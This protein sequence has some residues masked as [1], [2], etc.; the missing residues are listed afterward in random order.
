MLKKQDSNINFFDSSKILHY[1]TL[2]TVMMVEKTIKNAR[3]PINKAE[4]KRRMKVKTMHQTLSIILS[5]LEDRGMIIKA[6][7]GYV[8]IYNQSSKLEKAI[9]SGKEV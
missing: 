5:Y 6:K 2:K 8:W 4:I 3:S 9:R 7:D 1:P